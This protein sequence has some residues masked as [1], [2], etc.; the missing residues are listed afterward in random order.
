MSLGL[1]KNLNV[2]DKSYSKIN[3]QDTGPLIATRSFHSDTI[4]DIKSVADKYA[5]WT[6]FQ[7]F[8]MHV[9]HNSID[10][11]LTGKQPSEQI[12]EPV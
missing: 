10:G 11:W 1:Q 4:N 9:G 12:L 6:K 8:V 3:Q 2:S 7:T 5:Y